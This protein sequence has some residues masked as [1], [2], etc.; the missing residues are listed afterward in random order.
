ME[1]ETSSAPR[2]STCSRGPIDLPG[3]IIGAAAGLVLRFARDDDAAAII[4]LI[5]PVWSAYPGK[6]QV[7]AAD[8]PEL[9]TPATAY[10]RGN[11]RFWVVEAHGRIIGTIALMSSAEAGVVELQKLYVARG[12]RKNGL[13][14]F[15]CQL[16]ER[17][18]R[19]RG[20]H[21]IELWSDV[22]LLD[23][24]RRYERLGYDRGEVLKSYNDTS[25][26]VRYYYRKALHA[27]LPGRPDG[28]GDPVAGELGS[29]AGTLLHL[30]ADGVPM[31]DGTGIGRPFTEHPASVGEN[32]FEHLRHASGFAASMISGGL[33]CMVHAILPFMFTHTGSGVVAELNTRMV[34]NRRQEHPAASGRV[35]ERQA[36]PRR[37]TRITSSARLVAL[38]CTAEILCMAGFATYPA[39]LPV[40]R[41]DWA[42]SNTAAGFVGGILFFG[43]VVAVPVLTSLTDRIDARRVY[44]VSCLIAASGVGA[45]RPDGARVRRRADRPGAVRG[46]L[47]RDLHARPQGDVRPHRRGAAIARHRALHLAVR[48]WPRRLL[49]PDRR[50]LGACV[51]A[52]GVRVR[53]G[54]AAPGGAAGVPR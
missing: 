54:R 1:T 26:T 12:M 44:L 4:A 9:L 8:M 23:A 45:V 47:R 6:T 17:E 15:L 21:A 32:Y 50:R 52:A 48:V 18:A 51:V 31:T 14:S 19:E 41:A 13:G 35:G 33:A 53:D 42:L 22:K 16:V 39:L 20:A 28:A 40:L 43:Y 7:A 46:R 34:T 37:M 10:R 30:G 3:T 5:A 27:E 2:E 11:G 49:F 24:H 25:G 29:L 38:M 36:D